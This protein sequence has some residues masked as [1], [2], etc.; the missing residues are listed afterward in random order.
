MVTPKF[1]PN[2]FKK[3]QSDIKGSLDNFSKTFQDMFDEKIEQNE[4]QSYDSAQSYKIQYLNQ[5]G[6]HCTIPSLYV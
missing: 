6:V 5:Y 1:D 2:A 4:M 3:V